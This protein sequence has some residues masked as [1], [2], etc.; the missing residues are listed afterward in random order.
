VNRNKQPNSRLWGFLE[1]LRK[2]GFFPRMVDY[3]NVIRFLVKGK[4]GLD[5]LHV[6]NQMK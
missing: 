2:L 5:A 3:S 6:V 1:E 4:M